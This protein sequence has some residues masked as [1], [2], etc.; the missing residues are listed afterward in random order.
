MRNEYLIKKTIEFKIA[1]SQKIT[2]NS[3]GHSG[4]SFKTLYSG[5]SF[6]LHF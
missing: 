2:L 6:A 1:I 3:T 4:A 5:I